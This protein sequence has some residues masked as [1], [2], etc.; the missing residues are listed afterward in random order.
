MKTFWIRE[1]RKIIPFSNFSGKLNFRKSNSR[2]FRDQNTRFYR[3]RKFP[4]SFPGLTG[5]R[6]WMPHI[7]F[8][9]TDEK[10]LLA[11]G[12][13]N[14][15]DSIHFLRISNLQIYQVRKLFY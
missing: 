11:V 9:R 7:R 14:I 12:T 8:D 3:S 13:E 2:S 4:V 5:C 10:R 6:F 15:S 1:S